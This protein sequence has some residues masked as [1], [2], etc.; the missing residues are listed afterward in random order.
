FCRKLAFFCQKDAA[1][2]DGVFRRSQ[3]YRDK[4]DSM[5]GAV[6][7]GESTIARVIE[8]QGEIWD[9]CFLQQQHE[10]PSELIDGFSIIGPSEMLVLQFIYRKTVG[11]GKESDWIAYTQIA[12]ALK[13]DRETAAQV[14]QR[15]Q[16]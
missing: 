8:D 1:L 16:D 7:Y 11:F 15:L 12:K 9:P 2:I 4:W 3:L 14:C 5:R 10:I 13:M 6:T